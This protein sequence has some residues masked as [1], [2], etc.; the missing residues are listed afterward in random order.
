MQFSTKGFRKSAFTTAMAF[1]AANFL[2]LPMVLAQTSTTGSINGTVTDSTGAV[3]PGAAVVLRDAANGIVVNLT[4]N[5]EGRFTAP[6][7]APDT[8]SVSATAAGFQSNT[9]TVQVLTGQQTAVKMTVSPSTNTQTVQVN[10]NDAQLIDTQTANLTTTFT[11]QQFQSLPAPGGDITTIAYTVPGV[12]VGAGTEGFGGFTSDGLPGLSNLVVINGADYNIGLYG[13]LAFSGS[14]NLTIGQQEIAQAAVVQN[15][16]SVQYGRQAGVIETYATKSGSNRVHGLAQWQYNSSGLNANDFFNNLNGVPRPKAV[17]NQYAAQVGGPIKHDKLFFFVDTEGIRF[18]EPSVGFVNLPSQTL[19]NSILANPSITPGSKSLYTGMFKG[20]QAGGAYA[21]T[22]PVTTGPGSLQDPTGNYGCGQLAG[23][24]DY[25]SGGTLGTSAAESCV[26]SGFINSV[27]LNREWMAVGRLDWNISE[28][29]R[30]YFRVTDDQGNQPTYVSLINP[31]WSMVSNQPGWTGQLNDTY[32][33]NPNLTNQFLAAGLYYSGIFQP[34]NL[35]AGLAA[36]PTEFDQGFD[37]GTG[38]LGGIGQSTFFTGTTTL[39]A[40]WIDF[41]G[42]VNATQ[43]Q[44]VDNV[45]WQKGNHSIKFGFDFKRFLTSDVG[46]RTASY[47]G[48]YVFRTLADEAGGSLPGASGGSTF[49][50]G[51]PAFGN[52][53]SAFYNVGIYAQDEWKVLPNL[54]LDF[55]LR[56]DRNANPACNENCYSRYAGGFPNT[57]ATLNTPYNATLSAGHSSLLPSIEA[58]VVQPRFGFNL[59]L[60]GDGKTVVRGGVGL[61]A[62]NFPALIAEQTFLSFPNRYFASVLSGTVAQDAGSAFAVAQQ[63]ATAV[64][65][66]FAQGASYNQLVAAQPSFAPPNY[67]TTPNEFHGARYLEFSMQLQRQI[68]QRDAVILSYAGNHGYDLFVANDHLNQNV[69][70]VY[71]AYGNGTFGGLP[72]TSPDPRFALVQSF[73]ND[74]ISNY[75]GISVQYKH[76]DH[77]GLTTDIGYTY[78]HA[79][80]DISNGGNSQ[81]PYNSGSL[82]FQVTPGLPSTLMYSNSDY[83]IRHNFVMDLVYAEPHRFGNRI[84]NAVGAGWTVGAKAYWRSG[85]PFSVLNTNA[86]AGLAASGTGGS[87][88]LAEV[89]NNSINHS[90]TSYSHP[91]FQNFGAFNGTSPTAGPTLPGGGTLIQPVQTTFGNV[92]RNSFRG[93]HFADVDTTLFKDVYKKESLAFQVGAQAYNVLNH[94]NFAQPNSD[95]SNLSTL[96]QISGDINAPTSPYGSSQQPTVSGRVLVVQGR[97]VF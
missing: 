70:P 83:D 64:L 77:S 57:S 51:F 45:S 28:K 7:L 88:V 96:G 36:S 52:I 13:G 78:S 23:T 3:V 50:Q 32:T 40:P 59:D 47:G 91:C 29:H 72:A 26:N 39:G 2:S 12:V 22:V 71:A 24:K 43:Y 4:T 94:V 65:H 87:V 90:C 66:G 54:I 68:T 62:D 61:F 5:A 48:D 8:F 18:V 49:T 95:A 17:S 56:V 46:L 80:D 33:F 30:I 34:A 25:A 11:T 6:F 75:N 92:P 10:A 20:T 53:H 44:A 14:S 1:M 58:A 60:R 55:G 79:L 27:A 9:I 76:I 84:V 19:Q 73:S 31:N 16:Y 93:P 35:Q 63:S 86:S 38:T 97:L 89:L 37:G 67:V 82:S 42:G 41:P 21:K 69:G 85:E 74:A 15:G 81:L